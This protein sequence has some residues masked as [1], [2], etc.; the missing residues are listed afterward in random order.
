M[1]L[2]FVMLQKHGFSSYELVLNEGASPDTEG[3]AICG[4]STAG[5]V[6][7]IAASHVISS[8][9]LP[10]IGTVLNPEFPALA[11]VQDAIPKH[12]VRVYQGSNMGV[13]ISEIQFP[14]EQDISFAN[15]VLDWFV[16]GGFTHLI[17]VDGL[18]RQGS[19]A[20]E[21]GGLYGVGATTKAR[22]ILDKHD[23]Q[24]ILQGVV[25]GIPGYLLAEGDRRGLDVTALLAECNPMYPD[26]RAAA[27][28]VEA[29]TE[30]TGIE[31]PLHEL[32][33][34]ARKI[35]DSVREIFEESQSKLPAPNYEIET[36][37]DDPMV[38]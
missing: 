9:S 35:E 5:M 20:S 24:P 12:P 31:I 27:L 34:N 1:A 7:T 17:I 32:L 36:D 33:E 14:H 22:E 38:G 30:L 29:I 28:A 37:D 2:M 10:Q 3:I 4:F 8:L 13:F 11:L 15:T 21:T 6:G 18:V 23:I 25:G 16:K 19:E 26:A